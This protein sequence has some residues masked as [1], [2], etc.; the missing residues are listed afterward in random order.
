[1][2]RYHFLKF[3]GVKFKPL[4]KPKEITR[5]VRSLPEY[6]RDSFYEVSKELVDHGYLKTLGQHKTLDN[7]TYEIQIPKEI[8]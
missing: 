1:M 2:A 3:G 8:N 6:K 5:F 4:K 7:E